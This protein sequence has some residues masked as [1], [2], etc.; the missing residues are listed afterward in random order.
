MRIRITKADPD[1]KNC[2]ACWLE[3]NCFSYLAGVQPGV[4]L[5][6]VLLQYADSPG[7]VAP[8][9]QVGRSRGTR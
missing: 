1:P 8:V 2:R 5:V 4:E 3:D 6:P 9:A 7:M